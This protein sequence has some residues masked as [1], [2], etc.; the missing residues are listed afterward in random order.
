MDITL[1][2]FLGLITFGLFF[3]GWI[4]DGINF[5]FLFLCCP[6][7][8]ILSQNSVD[9]SW[10]Y[11]VN[12]NAT[13]S[14]YTIHDHSIEFFYLFIIFSGISLLG[15]ILKIAIYAESNLQIDIKAKLSK[16]WR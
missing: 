13:Y 11:A 14:T 12:L 10:S 7:F 5:V 16:L 8:Y 2:I 3:Y 1:F 9:I 6:L 4:K 15:L